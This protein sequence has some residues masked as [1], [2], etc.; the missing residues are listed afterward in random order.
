MG[1]KPNEQNEEQTPGEGSNRVARLGFIVLVQVHYWQGLSACG[2]ATLQ[3][4][5]A[6]IGGAK[7]RPCGRRGGTNRGQLGEYQGSK[8]AGLS[9]GPSQES[10]STQPRRGTSAT[11]RPPPPGPSRPR[12][13][14]PRAGRLAIQNPMPQSPAAAKNPHPPERKGAAQPHSRSPCAG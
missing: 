13:P 1:L 6:E 5:T 12:P 2:E 4:L 9:D 3:N 14:Q 11:Q 10:S 8:M 7:R